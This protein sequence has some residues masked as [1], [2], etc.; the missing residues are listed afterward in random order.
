MVMLCEEREREEILYGT[1][2]VRAQR[3]DK[4]RRGVVFERK[5]VMHEQ[6]KCEMH[7]TRNSHNDGRKRTVM[8]DEKG[9]HLEQES[10]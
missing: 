10:R 9:G 5:R 3:R 1:R 7:R 4:D 2:S 6:P 8:W